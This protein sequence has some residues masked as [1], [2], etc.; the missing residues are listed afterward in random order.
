MPERGFQTETWTDPWFQQL[1]LEQRYL[2]IY[3]WTN[4]HCN[5]AGLYQ[6]TIATLAFETKLSAE[7]LPELL[8][9][10]KPKVQW[11]PDDN[12]IWVRNFLRRQAKSSKFI[13]AATKSLNGARIPEEI[14]NDFE[15]Y[16][17]ELFRGIAPSEHVSPTKREC[18]IIRDDFRCQYCGKE[19][20]TADDYE[21]D[22]II[23]V[24]RGG[25]ENYLNLVAACRNCNQ[26]KIDKTPEEA[27]L[28]SPTAAPFH[29]AQATYI[30]RNNPAMREKWL[31]IF[32]DRY[33]VIESIL[34]NIDQYYPRIPS[35]AA[36]RSNASASAVSEEDRVVKGK[37]EKEIT[38]ESIPPS[39]SEIEESLSEGDRKVISVWRSVKGFSMPIEAAAELVA[40]LRTEFPDVDILD[41]SKVW[42]ARKLSEP[43]KAGSRVSAQIWN[44]M[45]KARQ[46]AQERRERGGQPPKGVRPKPAQERKRGPVPR[47]SGD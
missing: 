28:K 43:L 34:T 20:N 11:Y 37:G 1:E 26:K 7:Q 17:E 5:Q 47:I 41:E 8:E 32:P 38:G 14:R 45:K 27:G 22:H 18:V 24:T 12:L 16:N 33:K 30:L 40:R 2:F 35:N 25:K 46:F 19:I 6:I 44:W 29:G 10:L 42:A 4:E 23:P 9:S 15:A 31:K 3:L 21:M 39:K 36:S 13:I